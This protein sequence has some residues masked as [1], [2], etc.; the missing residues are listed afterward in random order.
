MNRAFQI[1]RENP[2]WRMV[3]GRLVAFINQEVEGGRVVRV[4]GYVTCHG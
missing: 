1:D 3:A 4:A 2:G